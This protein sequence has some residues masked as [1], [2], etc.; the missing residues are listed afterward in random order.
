[1]ARA[2]HGRQQNVGAIERWVRVPGGGRGS[3]RLAFL[4]AGPASLLL[5]LDFVVTGFA[6]HCPLYQRLGWN[7]R[8]A[9]PAASGR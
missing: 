3:R 5:G 4:L 2:Q 6:G 7:T 1:M 8:R 9:C